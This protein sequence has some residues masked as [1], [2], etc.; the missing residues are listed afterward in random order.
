VY[1]TFKAPGVSGLTLLVYAATAAAGASAGG[2]AGGAV[3]A[4]ALASARKHAWAS[5]ESVI[6]STAPNASDSRVEEVQQHTL[7]A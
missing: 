1:A 3:G 4:A 7:V 2:V 5:M 6:V